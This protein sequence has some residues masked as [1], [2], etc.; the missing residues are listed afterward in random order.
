MVVK[1]ISEARAIANYLITRGI[2]EERIIL[3]DQ[4]TTTYENLKYSQEMTRYLKESPKYLFVS[5]NY[6]IFRATLYAKRLHMNGEGVG[7]KTAGYYIPSAFLREYI[8]I[9][10]K[11]KMDSSNACIVVPTSSIYVK[12]VFLN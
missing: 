12:I 6:H 3:E 11:L 7:A 8:A 10:N 5:N 2:P 4:S 1:R 9:I